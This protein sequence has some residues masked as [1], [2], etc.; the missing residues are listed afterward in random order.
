MCKVSIIIPIYNTQKYLGKCLESVI[1]Q[2]LKD[3]EIILVNDGSIDESLRICMEYEKKDKRIKVIDKNNEGV[4]I[5]RNIG[6]ENSNGEYICFV[7]SDDYIEKDMLNNM[8]NS[9]LNNEADL[10]MCNYVKENIYKRDYIDCDIGKN[11]LVN[12]EIRNLLIFPLI[13]R[14]YNEK[15]HKLSGFRGPVAKLFKASIIKY[16]NIKFKKD[17]IIGED[18]IFN[19]EYLNLCK[20]IIIDRGYYYNYVTNEDSVTMKYKEDAWNKIYIKTINKLIEFLNEN[21]YYNI[22]KDRVNNIITKYFLICIW[23][24][25]NNKNKFKKLKIIKNICNDRIIKNALKNINI[26]IYRKKERLIIILAKCRLSY[27]IYIIDMIT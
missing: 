15:Y 22:S 5:A 24:E 25:K 17:L 19:L 23:N 9:I 7:D 14:G 21:N 4:S 10:C 20:K 12:D 27:L 18:F 26:N 2:T 6:I 16:N 11:I 1:D 3:I 8:Y 13:E